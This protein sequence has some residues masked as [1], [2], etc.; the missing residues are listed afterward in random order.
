MSSLLRYYS[1][2]HVLKK[3][4]RALVATAVLASLGAPYA[5]AAECHMHSHQEDAPVRHSD[6]PSRDGGPAALTNAVTGVVPHHEAET[7]HGPAGCGVA[8]L[9]P[10]RHDFDALLTIAPT[11]VGEIT[12][13]GQIVAILTTPV[14]PPPKN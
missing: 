9:G 3:C 4:A 13:R 7:C 5:Q 10:I 11:H 12:L 8:T 6:H 1:P 14:P 2:M